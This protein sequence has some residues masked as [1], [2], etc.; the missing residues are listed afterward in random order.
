MSEWEFLYS[1][2]LFRFYSLGEHVD[3]FRINIS[4]A[5][6]NG[7]TD[8]I[9]DVSNDFQNTNVPVHERVCIITPPYYLV[10]FGKYYTNVP[11]NQGY[12]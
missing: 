11:L 8:K 9:L 5:D 6:M 10:C 7:I 2:H 12:S 1:R 3:S 4:I